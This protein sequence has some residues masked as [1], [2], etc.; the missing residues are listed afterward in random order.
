VVISVSEKCNTSIFRTENKGNM[1]TQHFSNTT[2][3]HLPD[4]DN[5]FAAITT[6]DLRCCNMSSGAGISATDKKLDCLYYCPIHYSFKYN[7]K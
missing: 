2:Q 6:P 7:S 5:I 1:L 3:N 4:N